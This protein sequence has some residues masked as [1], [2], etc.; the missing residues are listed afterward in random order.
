M[1]RLFLSFFLLLM[2]LSA[3]ATHN[4]GGEITYRHVSG[5]TYEITVTTITFSESTADR[6]ELEIF[7]GDGKSDI[8]S[9]VNGEYGLSPSGYYCMTGELLDNYNDVRVNKYVATHTYPGNGE[10][11]I[12]VEDPNRNYGVINIP[13]S[14]NVPFYIESCLLIDNFLGANNSP[15]TTM[16]PVDLACVGKLFVT[17][18]GAYDVDG[19]SLSFELVKCKGLDGDDIPGYSLPDASD[20]LSLDSVSGNFI[21]NTPTIQ[22]EFN[23]AYRIY[24]WRNSVCIGYVTRDFQVIVSACNN[25][26]PE[27]QIVGQECAVAGE[28]FTLEIIATD[29]DNDLLNLE[30]SG[31]MFE[32]DFGAT[33]SIDTSYA[34]FT[35]A[36]VNWQTSCDFISTRDYPIYIRAV[37]T[38]NAVNLSNFATF[39]VNVIGDSPVLTDIEAV[40]NTI[41]LYWQKYYCKDADGYL[42]YRTSLTDD[43]SPDYC[44][45]GIP[46][47]LGYVNVG[48]V[49]QNN[50]KI[51][52]FTD[53]GGDSGLTSG[54]MYIYRIVAFWG[55]P[56]NP[57]MVSKVSDELSTSLSKD[58]P[59]IT[60][61]SVVNT[62]TADGIVEVMFSPPTDIDTTIFP[63]PYRVD[64]LHSEI[65]DDFSLKYSVSDVFM[66]TVFIHENINT[67]DNQHV[68]YLDFYD[69]STEIPYYIGKS[70]LSSSLFLSAEHRDRS[71]LLKWN[72]N[73]PWLIDYYSVFLDDVLVADSVTSQEFLVES[74]TNGVEYDF[75]VASYGGFIDESY[76]SPIINYSQVVSA[77]PFDNEPP[78]APSLYVNVDCDNM[79]NV[80]SWS[81]PNNICCDDVAMYNVYYQSSTGDNFFLLDSVLYAEDTVY[82]HYNDN[83]LAGCYYVEAV[84]VNENV[85]EPSN[86]IVVYGDECPNYVLPNVFTPNGDGYN[87]VFVPISYSNVYRVDMS[88]YNRQG[89]LLFQTDEPKILWDGKDMLT[90]KDVSVGVYFYVCV[91]YSHSYDGDFET[92]LNGYIHLFR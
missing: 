21:W 39:N 71:V 77:V 9:R 47:N 48:T 75:Q 53:D 84:D 40:R 73:V 15:Q 67:V 18:P 16:Y 35:Q 3:F 8:I 25:E 34:G 5:Y 61:T 37:E 90:K 44:D 36:T 65:D 64:V 79:V 85:S 30:I 52:S 4:R 83:K 58:L 80:L 33:I 17:N 68:Y 29:E 27:I 1:K 31:E 76:P 86:T 42:V 54:V 49:T 2:C 22:G 60:K 41:S 55:N 91:V 82:I 70:K 26:P 51:L 12:S 57:S 23:F 11:I 20:F 69:E 62:D 7:W 32:P 78:C 13:N 72:C 56:D 92:V 89:R 28:N 87:D 10:F 19:D 46:T 24:E 50:A 63:G 88:I 59:V 38:D 43:Y 66:D 6:C 45:V 74:L 81:N 14:V